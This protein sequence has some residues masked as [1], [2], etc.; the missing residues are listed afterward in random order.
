MKAYNTISNA[1][2]LAMMDYGNPINWKTSKQGNSDY[3]KIYLIPYLK[4]VSVC[5]KPTD[6]FGATYKYLDG[7]SAADIINAVFGA[8]PF[9]IQL[10]DGVA[11]LQ[12]PGD[13]NLIIDTNGQKGP[14]VFGRDLF[15]P[16]LTNE[17]LDDRKREMCN[18]MPLCL[19]GDSDTCISLNAQNEDCVSKLI[20]EGAMNY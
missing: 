2:N 19:D 14:N 9:T 18:G 6:C 12:L 11:I 8:K 1:L 20:I 7:T 5:E 4:N 10:P 17:G 13:D 3:I 16:A 15:V